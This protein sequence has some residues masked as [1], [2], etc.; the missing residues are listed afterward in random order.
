[1]SASTNFSGWTGR[2]SIRRTSEPKSLRRSFD[3]PRTTSSPRRLSW[4]SPYMDGE[5]AEAENG[6]TR[7][8][9]D[10]A[11]PSASRGC[12]LESALRDLLKAER[13]V[14]YGRRGS[15][16]L[17]KSPFLPQPRDSLRIKSL[18]KN[19]LVE[20]TNTKTEIFDMRVFPALEAPDA[21]DRLA[22]NTLIEAFDRYV[23]SDPQ[24]VQLQA[25]ATAAGGEALAV[26]FEQ[27]LLKAIWPVDFGT[28]SVWKTDIG[29]TYHNLSASTEAL[30]RAADRVL[31][32]RFGRLIEYLSSGEL[33]AQGLSRGGEL[34]TVPRG[35]WQR[36]KTYLDLYNGDLLE[37]TR[38]MTLNTRLRYTKSSSVV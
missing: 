2:G 25:R 6:L 20:R 13:I 33:T 10:A 3:A 1:M 12:E 28:A 29:I 16:W 15:R 9:R 30:C 5:A 27:R 19:I 32:K 24:H 18:R 34:T 31:I 4:R 17:I 7:Q 11:R 21:I 22:G 8:Y 37:G 35:L 14:A 26:S 36:Y 38:R 23:F